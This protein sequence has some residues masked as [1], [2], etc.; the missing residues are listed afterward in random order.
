MVTDSTT[1]MLASSRL[2]TPK[3]LTSDSFFR[4]VCLCNGMCVTLV[5]VPQGMRYMPQSYES[6]SVMAQEQHKLPGITIDSWGGGVPMAH[7]ALRDA[8]TYTPN[9]CCSHFVEYSEWA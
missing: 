7:H 6:K 3:M 4:C 2:H 5:Y 8:I 1:R 9:S